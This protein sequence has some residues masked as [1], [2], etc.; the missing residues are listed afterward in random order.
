[1]EAIMTI[2]QAA[3]DAEMDLRASILEAMRAGS[4]VETREYGG[5]PIEVIAE[6]A[7]DSVLPGLARA[8]LPALPTSRA[9]LAALC[10]LLESGGD[11]TKAAT[12]QLMKLA[13]ES[14]TYL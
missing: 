8:I 3:D 1:M 9:R 4:M 2:R 5:T 7:V 13:P 6:V 12:R 11:I 10:R 14:S